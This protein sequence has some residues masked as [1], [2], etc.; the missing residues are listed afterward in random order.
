[1]LYTLFSFKYFI[2][3]S[4]VFHLDVLYIILKIFYTSLECSIHHLYISCTI[5]MFYT[6]FGYLIHHITGLWCEGFRVRSPIRLEPLYRS[7]SLPW[8][9]NLKRFPKLGPGFK[10]GNHL[11]TSDWWGKWL[12]LTRVSC[13]PVV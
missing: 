1:M 12:A 10:I 8:E 6:L 7:P 5:W 13:P 4:H 9:S 11:S 3:H 2:H